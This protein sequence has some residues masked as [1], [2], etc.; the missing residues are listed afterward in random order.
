M[1]IKETLSR[2]CK[3]TAFRK[4]AQRPSSW[5]PQE[6]V[7]CIQIREQN[8]YDLKTAGPQSQLLAGIVVDKPPSVSL[9]RCVSGSTLHRKTSRFRFLLFFLTEVAV[10]NCFLKK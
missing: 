4:R 7:L 10:S 1:K 3:T 6:L 2:A 5:S 9:K 8:R